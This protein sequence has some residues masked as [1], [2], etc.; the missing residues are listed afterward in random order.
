VT[1]SRNVIIA[2]A[3]I[4]GL[5]A[6]LMLARSGFRATL[7]ERTARLE[8]TG[9]G[10]QLPPN[11]TRILFALGLEQRLRREVVAPSAVAV[12]TATGGRLAVAPL[13]AEAERRYGAPYW[14]IHRGDL[15]AAL[16]EAVHAS[17][18]IVLRLGQRVEDFV[19][20]AHGVSAACRQ[21]AVTADEQGIALIGADGLWSGLRPRL[22][23]R[24]QPEFQRRTAWRALIA[25]DRVEP[26]F[27]SDEVQLWLGKDA[28]L[29]HYPVKG[30]KLINIVAIVADQWSQ[31]GWS[32]DGDRAELLAHFS[33][34]NWC[35]PVREFLSLPERW[36]K[37]ALY[38]LPPLRGWGDGAVTLLGDAAHPMLPFLAQGAAMAIEDAAVLADRLARDP[39]DPAKALRRY[40]RARR[41][42]TARVQRAARRNGAIYHLVGAEALL[43]NL[44]L[45]AAGG[46]LLRRRTHW[47]YDWRF[48][49]ATRIVD[50]LP[51]ARPGEE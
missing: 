25:A 38:D 17:P 31:Q 7:I 18:D 30:G 21:A 43:R 48:A 40:E 13:G 2:G 36:L 19:L 51:A 5:T 10:I 14:C 3:G 28:H 15:Q 4:G 27:R 42:R 34:W 9:A 46:L 24:V 44:A 12:K 33:P 39:G 45:R 23:H 20:H 26:E 8:E 41:R 11:A 16:L 22:G 6:A 35:E 50:A 37:W 32:A 47:L 49:P 1:S 29:V